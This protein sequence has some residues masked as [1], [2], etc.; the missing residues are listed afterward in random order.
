MICFDQT[1]C[2]GNWGASQDSA[3]LTDLANPEKQLTDSSVAGRPG[4]IRLF[5]TFCRQGRQTNQT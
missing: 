2:T 4:Q 5:D 3:K 1:A